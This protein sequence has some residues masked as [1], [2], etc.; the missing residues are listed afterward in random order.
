MLKKSQAR[1]KSRVPM[2]FR[3]QRK[4][5]R[6]MMQVLLMRQKLKRPLPPMKKPEQRRTQVPKRMPVLMMRTARPQRRKV[7]QR[8][9]I[10]G[11]TRRL[12]QM[13][14]PELQKKRQVPKPKPEHH[15]MA[16]LEPKTKARRPK[17]WKLPMN[18]RRTPS[19]IPKT[20]PQLTKWLQQ[21]NHHR[22]YCS[23]SIRVWRPAQPS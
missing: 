16:M 13:R 7:P 21:R 9:K 6:T 11:Q 20:N 5:E 4:Q 14:R 17:S 2:S 19:A 3:G 8:K 18:P 23:L 10:Q 12:L 1:R 15:R 22:V